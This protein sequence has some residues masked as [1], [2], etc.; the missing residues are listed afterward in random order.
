MP[1]YAWRG[2]SS[3]GTP[4][5]GEMEAADRSQVAR[6]LQGRGITPISIEPV[7]EQ[8]DDLSQWRRW[9]GLDKPSLDDL[10]LFSR[11]MYTLTRAGVPLIQGLNSIAA[12]SRNAALKRGISRLAEALE[13]GSGL[14]EGLSRSRDVF[15]DMFISV[16][17][18]GETSGNLQ[19][20]FLQMAHYL[21]SER[22]FRRRVGAALRYPFLVVAA[23]L[24]SVTIIL[25]WVIPTFAD[26]FA[27][28]QVDL[29][30]PTR[31]IMEASNIVTSLW[32]VMALLLVAGWLGFRFWVRTRDGLLTWDHTKLRIP[33]FG[34]ILAHA[35]MAR[36]ARSF[37]MT[38]RAGVSPVQGLSLVSRSLENAYIGSQCQ[39]ISSGIERGDSLTRSVQSAGLFTPLLI[40]MISVGEETGDVA[41][42]LEETADHYEREVDHELGNMSAL[43]EPFLLLFLGVLLLILTLGVF[44]PMW[45]LSQAFR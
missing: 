3:G 30:L 45:D 32:W 29:P 1:T 22:D 35:T 8:A 39:K 23:M 37:G 2:R 26:F 14:A 40:Q 6:Q 9:F 42:M 24:M 12:S 34:R 18:V 27:R 33:I 16:V 21:E 44:L 38:M 5:D 10:V 11:Q 17:R 7:R 19:Q 15:P 25:L 28:Q 36:F 4:Q 13:S 20:A 41:Q 43:I 31:I